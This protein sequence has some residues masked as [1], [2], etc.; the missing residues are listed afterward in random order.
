VIVGFEPVLEMNLV[1]MGTNDFFP[2][3][4]VSLQTKGAGS[5]ARTATR[6]WG[7]AIKAECAL[8]SSFPLRRD[9]FPPVCVVESAE[10]CAGH[11]LAVLGEGMSVVTL[12]Q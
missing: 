10:N 6:N 1:P 2:N 4:F 3:S 5:P 11:D 9:P 8:S 12:Q 7:G